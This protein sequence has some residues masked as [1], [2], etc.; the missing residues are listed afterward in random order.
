MYRSKDNRPSSYE[1]G[2]DARWRRLRKQK[3]RANPLCEE[4]DKGGILERATMVHH[5]IP[6]EDGGEALDWDNL[7]SLCLPCHGAKHN[8]TGTENVGGCDVSGFPISSQH[9]WSKK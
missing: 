9:P 3:L 5:I 1:R 6:I 8:T 4:C 2:Y 7:M